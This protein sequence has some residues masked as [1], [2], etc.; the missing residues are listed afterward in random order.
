MGRAAGGN[1]VGLW[2]WV[3]AVLGY[4]VSRPQC[5]FRCRLDCIGYHGVDCKISLSF[6][7]FFDAQAAPV[8]L[9]EGHNFPQHAKVYELNIHDVVHR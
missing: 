6:W 4:P 5:L 8:Q 9:L 3:R 7:G 2:A 1:P